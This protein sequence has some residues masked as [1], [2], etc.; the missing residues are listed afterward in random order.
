MYLFQSTVIAFLCRKINVRLKA[1]R[2]QICDTRH[3]DGRRPTTGHLRSQRASIFFTI[4][5]CP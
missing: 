2:T 5:E 4:N 3:E 1:L